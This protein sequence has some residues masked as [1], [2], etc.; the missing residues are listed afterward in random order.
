M[1]INSDKDLILGYEM[2]RFPPLSALNV[3][4]ETCASLERGEG[5]RLLDSCTYGDDT[6]GHICI[7]EHERT[8]IQSIRMD[9]TV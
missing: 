1:V 8:G 7:N 6:I 2:A 9:L 4:Q 5:H 3:V